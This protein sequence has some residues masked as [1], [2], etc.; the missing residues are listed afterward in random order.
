MVGTESQNYAGW[1]VQLFINKGNR[2]FVDETAARLPASDSS[3]GFGGTRFSWASSVQVLDFNQDGAQDFFLGFASGGR[4]VTRDMPLVWLN[5]GTGQFSTLKVGDF[6]TPGN[7]PFLGPAPRL[8][9]TRNGYSFIAPRANGRAL[10]I[11]GLLATKPYLAQ[12]Q[13]RAANSR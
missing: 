12:K 11:T 9:A 3:G 10:T 7:E 5:D 4:G 1:F 13:L 6:V 2:Q 8:V